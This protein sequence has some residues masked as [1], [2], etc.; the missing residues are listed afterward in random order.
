MTAAHNRLAAFMVVALAGLS[1]HLLWPDANERAQYLSI[2]TMTIGYGHLLGASPV[3]RATGPEPR[4]RGRLTR[5]FTGLTAVLILFAVYTRAV[6]ELE[7]EVRSAGPLLLLGLVAVSIWHTV[8]NDVALARLKESSRARLRISGEESVIVA[9]L[10]ILLLLLAMNSNWSPW[11]SSQAAAAAVDILRILSAVAGLGCLAAAATRARGVGRSTQLGTLGLSCLAASFGAFEL[12]PAPSGVE[13]VIAIVLYHL[14]CWILLVLQRATVLRRT[15]P[16]AARSSLRRLAALHAVPI[17]GL[18]SFV[19]WEESLTALPL[20]LLFSPGIYLFF[21]AAHVVQT[22]VARG[23][24]R[25]GP[26]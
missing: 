15:E 6:N 16:R 14:V 17:F 24:E 4:R 18:V 26:R 19:V 7:A 25:G 22:A 11:V 9:A 23:F 3:V 8:E 20:A 12:L 13:V 1:S 2:L 21:S 10:S 5:P